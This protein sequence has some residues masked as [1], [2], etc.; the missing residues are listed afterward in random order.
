MICN[1]VLPGFNADPSILWANGACWIATST[2]EWYPGVSLYRSE[3][4]RDWVH[5]RNIL[6]RKDQL[7]L[8]GVGES[9]GIW[10]PHISY[11]E[12]D[13]LWFLAYTIVSNLS[14]SYFD[15]KNYLVHSRDPTGEW[16]SPRFLGSEGFDPALFHD[17]DGRTWMTCLAWEFR[18]GYKHPGKIILRETDPETGAAL[19][20]TIEISDGNPNFGCTEG[21]QIYKR[22]DWY[23]LL[24]AEGGTGYGHAVLVYR[25][26]KISG[27][28]KPSPFGP[29]LTAR[30]NPFPD[31][32]DT[33]PDFLKLRFYNP[34]SPLQKTGHG[35]LVETPG[36]ETYLSHLCARPAGTMHRCILNRETA[37]QKIRWD[38]DWPRLENGG[39]LPELKIPVPQGVP[40]SADKTLD[41]TIPGRCEFTH[42]RLPPHF[43]SL[44]CPVEE[45]WCS[46]SRIPGSLSLRGRNSLYDRLETSLIARRVQHFEFSADTL[47]T[48]TPKDCRRMA[49][50]IL[51]NSPGTWYFL[52]YYFSE[53]LNTPALGIMLSDLGHPDELTEARTAVPEEVLSLRLGV[54]V[55]G[56]SLQFYQAPEH[57]ELRPVGPE[58]D[59]SRLSDEYTNNGPGAFSGTFLGFHVQDLCDQTSWASFSYLN[60]RPASGNSGSFDPDRTAEITQKL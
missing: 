44:R 20:D 26:R 12:S 11:R 2:F 42:P 55:S 10:A 47:M 21:P 4:L 7:E 29:V 9:C 3:N 51:M 24:N 17:S 6:T 59:M 36:K 52:R 43:H 56:E 1:P 48:F 50:L 15:L 5:V 8:R 14:E 37:L 28:Y 60:Y 40:V 54:R 57:G 30:K 41:V 35:Y 22:N 39:H 46:L 33:D 53:T 34:E 32:P 31:Q 18:K 19:G 16:S 13:G 45:D 27:P 38:E 58:L 23:Y 49:G 25:S